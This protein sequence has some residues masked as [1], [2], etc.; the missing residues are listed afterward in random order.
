[1]RELTRSNDPVWLSWLTSLLADAGIPSHLL[2]T[3]M[4]LLEGSIAAIPRRV[5]VAD[6]DFDEARRLMEAGKDAVS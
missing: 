4:S 1:M 3:H 2:D 6:E 5:M